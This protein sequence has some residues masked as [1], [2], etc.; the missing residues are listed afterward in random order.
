[1]CFGHKKN[2]DCHTQDIKNERGRQITLN[3]NSCVKSSTCTFFFFTT[4]GS[5]I[6]ILVWFI[7]LLLRA[8]L[9]D[10][11]WTSTCLAKTVKP[12]IK[13]EIEIRHKTDY[14]SHSKA[15]SEPR[16]CSIEAACFDSLYICLGT[17]STLQPRCNDVCSWHSHRE[18]TAVRVKVL[19]S[20]KRQHEWNLS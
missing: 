15:Q 18:C 10:E 11:L 13:S 20:G 1:M 12:C 17:N 9:L 16:I 4:R 7:T 8:L 19:R 14:T 6:L 3:M 5:G 2:M